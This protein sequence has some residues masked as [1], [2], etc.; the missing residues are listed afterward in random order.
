MLSTGQDYPSKWRPIHDSRSTCRGAAPSRQSS[1]NR[2]RLHSPPMTKSLKGL[3]VGLV[4]RDQSGYKCLSLQLSQLLSPTTV[5][6]A[7]PINPH[8]Q[9]HRRQKTSRPLAIAV[10]P[11][12]PTTRS[13][14]RSHARPLF[15]H[16]PMS[17]LL[18]L[19]QLLSLLPTFHELH[20]QHF[21]P[22]RV[23]VSLRGSVLRFRISS[24]ATLYSWLSKNDAPSNRDNIPN[25]RSLDRSHALGNPGVQYY[26]TW[27]QALG[28]Q[29]AHATAAVRP[30]LPCTEQPRRHI[31]DLAIVASAIGPERSI[32][33]TSR[34]RVSRSP[35][36]IREQAVKA[37]SW[38][39]NADAPAFLK[40]NVRTTSMDKP[41]PRGAYSSITTRRLHLSFWRLLRH[42]YRYRDRGT[43]QRD[44]GRTVLTIFS[45]YL[46]F[47]SN[48]FKPVLQALELFKIW[49]KLSLV[50]GPRSHRRRYQDNQEASEPILEPSATQAPSPATEDSKDGTGPT[51]QIL[52][53]PN[54]F[55]RCTCRPQK[56]P[57]IYRPMPANITHPVA[58]YFPL[59]FTQTYQTFFSTADT[60]SHSTEMNAELKVSWVPS[61]DIQ[62]H[63][64]PI[65]YRISSLYSCKPLPS[66]P[67]VGTSRAFKPAIPSASPIDVSTKLCGSG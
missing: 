26:R 45:G 60:P 37:L 13:A 51:R 16:P 46:A 22:G 24:T 48:T 29:L 36:T 6:P 43:S 23:P 10:H 39:K 3:P 50:P 20:L 31:P 66:I 62:P 38:I 59:T 7:G 15:S 52:S 25:T 27:E 2:L 41:Q 67:L 14:T 65:P 18:F 8:R 56:L 57:A 53:W 34:T 54:P 5:P 35:I 42:I 33:L 64:S 58:T 44:C 17:A 28:I 21:K 63:S 40:D 55:D 19:T 11:L 47:A 9:T 32:P 1:L 49:P 61:P 4:T 12:P 30:F